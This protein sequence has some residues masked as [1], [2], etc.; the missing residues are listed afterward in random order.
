MSSVMYFAQVNILIITDLKSFSLLKLV[1][2]KAIGVSQIRWT[3]YLG[4]KICKFCID[5]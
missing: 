4:Y 1:V 5:Y 3:Q 2:L